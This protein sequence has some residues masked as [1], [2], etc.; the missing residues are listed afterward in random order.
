ME[1]MV[2]MNVG[3][4]IL[5]PDNDPY[6]SHVRAVLEKADLL[7]GQLEVPYTTRDQKAV[8]LGREPNNLQPLVSSGFDLVT[9]AGNHFHDAGVAGIQDTITWLKEHTISYLGAGMNIDEARKAVIIERKGTR[10]G[11]LDYNCV[12]PKEGWA[13][14]KRAGVSYIHIISHYEEVYSTPGGPPEIFSWPEERSLKR[15]E[16]DIRELRTEC[17]VLIVTLH[18]GIGHTPVKLAQYEQEI[19]YAAIDAGADIVIGHHAHILRGIEFYQGKPIFHGLCNFVTWV[20]F[21]ASLEN[22]ENDPWIQ[23]RRELF[24]FEPNP[25]YP[26]YP[27]HPEAIYS[28]IAKF[29]IKNK[30]ISNISYIPLRMNKQGMPEVMKRDEKGQEVFEYIDSITQKAG[31]NARFK[32]DGEEV[33]VIETKDIEREGNLIGPQ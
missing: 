22:K 17:D 3:D 21:L 20:P 7:V 10:I 24:G 9:L 27:F 15:M 18:K 2:L 5:G 16:A 28:M 31:L 32:W 23:K 11:F 14:E 8:S 12:G 4:I 26:T 33:T 1:E 25:E 13:T 6:F 30:K 19:S 29:T